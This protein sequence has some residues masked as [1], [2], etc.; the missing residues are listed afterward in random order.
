MAAI[1]LIIILLIFRKLGFSN[2]ILKAI[3]ESM[4]A[5]YI[6]NQLIEL[7]I[8]EY[9][10]FLVAGYLNATFMHSQPFGDLLSGAIAMY[11]LLMTIVIIPILSI[12]IIAIDT[13]KLT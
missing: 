5:T 4:K 12:F 13:N 3:T 1:F 7:I 6:F 9:F 2:N 10:Q 8:N 11:A